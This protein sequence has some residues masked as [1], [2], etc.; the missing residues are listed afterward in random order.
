VIVLVTGVRPSDGRNSDTWATVTPIDR[1]HH[2][3]G[4]PSCQWVD[5]RPSI[6]GDAGGKELAENRKK[7]SVKNEKQ[8]I[9]THQGPC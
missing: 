7:I 9:T 1:L 6:N 3:N 2:E 8:K 4:P 5:A